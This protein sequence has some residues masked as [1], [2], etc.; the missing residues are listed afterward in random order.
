MILNEKLSIDSFKE[1]SVH[2]SDDDMAKIEGGTLGL[3]VLFYNMALA[4]TANSV[5]SS[6]FLWLST[7]ALVNHISTVI[8]TAD[9][10]QRLNT[11][12][13]MALSAYNAGVGYVEY[14]MTAVID[15]VDDAVTGTYEYIVGASGAGSF[16]GGPFND[17]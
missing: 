16:E 17:N 5:L 11:A 14:G 10:R 9:N 6:V 13:D 3:A 15:F 1:S 12:S 2:L 8:N 4:T 7:V